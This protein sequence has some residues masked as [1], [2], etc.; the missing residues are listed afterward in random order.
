MPSNNLDTLRY[1]EKPKRRAKI[2]AIQQQNEMG[3]V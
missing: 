2:W 3:N 1:G